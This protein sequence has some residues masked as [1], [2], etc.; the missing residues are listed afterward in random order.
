MSLAIT[1]LKLYPIESQKVVAMVAG[2][3]QYLHSVGRPLNPPTVHNQSHSRYRS[4]KASYSNFSP[5][6]CCHGNVPLTLDLGYVF[7]GQLDP[8]NIGYPCN[9][10]ACR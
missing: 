2:Y 7:I 5:K 9:Q 6:T 8:E 1:Q 10:T 4:H 3:R